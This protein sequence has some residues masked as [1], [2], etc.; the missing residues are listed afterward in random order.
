MLNVNQ[1]AGQKMQTQ[2]IPLLAKP[3]AAQLSGKAH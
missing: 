3:N 2:W 1:S